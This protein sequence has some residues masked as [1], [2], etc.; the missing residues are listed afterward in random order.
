MNI[1]QFLELYNLPKV[2][3]NQDHYYPMD[4]II[5]P[6]GKDEDERNAYYQKLAAESRRASEIF[7]RISQRLLPTQKIKNS[8]LLKGA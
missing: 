1:I 3:E 4:A 7:S 5:A 2:L 8:I 6:T